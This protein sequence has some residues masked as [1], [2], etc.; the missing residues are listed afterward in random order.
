[1]TPD[2]MSLFI[3]LSD[4]STFDLVDDSF[5]V[6]GPNDATEEEIKLALEQQ[7]DGP[8]LS[9]F[10][11]HLAEEGVA[12]VRKGYQHDLQ[13]QFWITLAVGLTVGYIIGRFVC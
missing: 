12:S 11:I 4:G 1:M 5:I 2:G 8:N 6:M 9:E 7:A 3:V 10:M 13:R